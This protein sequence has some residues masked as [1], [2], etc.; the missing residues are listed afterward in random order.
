MFLWWDVWS[1]LLNHTQLLVHFTNISPYNFHILLKG[2]IRFYVLILCLTHFL[3]LIDEQ[4][5]IQLF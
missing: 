2:A 4:L 5:V 3:L 1:T